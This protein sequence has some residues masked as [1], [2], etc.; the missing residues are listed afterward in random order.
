MTARGTFI[1]IAATG[2]SCEST[3]KSRAAASA[4]RGAG[5]GRCS[6]EADTSAGPSTRPHATTAWRRREC[7]TEVRRTARCV[8]AWIRSNKAPHVRRGHD[9]DEGEG[10]PT[11]CPRSAPARSSPRSRRSTAHFPACAPQGNSPQYGPQTG[12]VRPRPVSAGVKRAFGTDQGVAPQAR[13]PRVRRHRRQAMPGDAGDGGRLRHT[14]A[15]SRRSKATTGPSCFA[16]VRGGYGMRDDEQAWLGR[17]KTGTASPLETWRSADA[18]KPGKCRAI[19]S[20]C[21]AT[22]ADIAPDPRELRDEGRRQS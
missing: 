15:W 11:T 3:Q 2:G 21:L 16:L 10:Q 12:H 4:D 13:W 14:K 9:G 18:S 1:K 8:P 22:P 5:C 6:E 20:P 17:L 19:S 7:G